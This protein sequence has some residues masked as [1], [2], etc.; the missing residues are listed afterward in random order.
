[1]CSE[2]IGDYVAY[3]GGQRKLGRG[4]IALSVGG[5]HRSLLMPL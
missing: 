1:M 4:V 3:F 2:S 5:L